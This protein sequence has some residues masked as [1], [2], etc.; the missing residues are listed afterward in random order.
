MR[1]LLGV[2]AV[3]VMVAA[4]TLVV[5]GAAQAAPIKDAKAEA[6]VCEGED[7]TIYTA[8][9]NGWID[10]VLYKAASFTVVGTFTP[11]G[12]EPEPFTETQTWGGGRSGPGEITCTQH[13]EE[14]EPGESR[15]VT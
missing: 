13:F 15:W 7:V 3:A 10:G 12:G 8:G 1:K 5:G 11:T 6:W 9:R 2:T 4:S 14:T